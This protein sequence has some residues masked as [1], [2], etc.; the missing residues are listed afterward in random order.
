M[1]GGLLVVQMRAASP[2]HARA[3][4][5]TDALPS[6]IYACMQTKSTPKV[7]TS[8][9]TRKAAVGELSQLQARDTI[10]ASSTAHEERERGIW[11][12]SIA[13]GR[14]YGVQP[15]GREAAADGSAAR[16]TYTERGA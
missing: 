12:L 3:E 7:P 16:P 1:E 9:C 5:T 6:A 11:T 4:I 10:M 15:E 2:S 13:S 14:V 8:D